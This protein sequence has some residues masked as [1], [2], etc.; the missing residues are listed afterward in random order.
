M[1]RVP[2]ST[3]RSHAAGISLDRLGYGTN[4]SKLRNHRV[5]GS[6]SWNPAFTS[7]PL[8]ILLVIVLLF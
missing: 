3:V 6:R 1:A 8:V 2:A 7:T 4:Q 5:S